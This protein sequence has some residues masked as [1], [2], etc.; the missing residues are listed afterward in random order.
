MKAHQYYTYLHMRPD[1]FGIE[2]V[3]Y[4]GKGNERRIKKISRKH[5]NHHTRI[6]N[7]VGVENVRVVSFPCISEGAAFELEKV[8]IKSLRDAGVKLCNQTDGG[9]G[10]SG[11][12][13]SDAAR[14]KVSAANIGKFVS[15]ETRAKLSAAQKGR[16]HTLGSNDQHSK[17]VRNAPVSLRNKSGHKG[18]CWKRLR[19]RWEASIFA[20]GKRLHLGSFVT[21]EEAVLARKLGELKYWK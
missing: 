19:S 12:V 17:A 4:V 8:L 20:D 2:S 15:L 1:K 6:V 21:K 11:L 3:F 10:A 7:K 5:N 13:H 9:E 18:V 16:K 14:A